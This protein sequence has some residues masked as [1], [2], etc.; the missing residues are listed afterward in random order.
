MT[1]HHV[2]ALLIA[3]AMVLGAAHSPNAKDVMPSVLQLAT[4]ISAG[5]FGHAGAQVIQRSKLHT[6]EEGQPKT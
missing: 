1:W 3:G 5:V 2:M 4:A 6:K